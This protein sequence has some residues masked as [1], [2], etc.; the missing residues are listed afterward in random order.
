[1]P[2]VAVERVTA[3]D[4]GESDPSEDYQPLLLFE[5]GAEELFSEEE[6]VGSATEKLL[7]ILEQKKGKIVEE[8]INR[9]HHTYPEETANFLEE[10]KNEFA[11]PIGA[12]IQ[13]SVWPLY[14]EI[15][16]GHDS[17]NLYKCLDY[18]IRVR[19]V[20]DFTPTAAVAVVS[21]LKDIMREELLETIE[22]QGLYSEYLALE[23]RIDNAI[24]AAF[25]IYMKCRERVWEIRHNDIT[26]R[27][28][29]LS[30]GMCASYMLRR[31]K[32]HLEK[33]KCGKNPSLN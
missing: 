9:I 26:Q 20:Q 15:I 25:D 32:K 5:G 23:T 13:Q 31:G 33:M 11:N 1:M 2:K 18:L 29:I 7:N 21:F 10:E 19:A 30:G 12:S 22:E 8:W 6:S 3:A 28:F 17:D 24:M 16:S 14:D 27:P 4:V